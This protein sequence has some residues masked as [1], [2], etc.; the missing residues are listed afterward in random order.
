[1]V[2][3]PVTLKA[4]LNTVVVMFDEDIVFEVAGGNDSKLLLRARYIC[5][6]PAQRI[7]VLGDLWI[8]A[9]LVGLIGELVSKL[10]TGRVHVR[11]PLTK[12]LDSIFVLVIGFSDHLTFELL[13]IEL[14][15]HEGTSDHNIRNWLERHIK[16]LLSHKAKQFHLV[17]S[18]SGPFG[19]STSGL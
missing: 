4:K 15:N 7:L 13:L 5:L 19:R 17:D 16:T 12:C 10:P 18:V 8:A 3:F 9:E 6:D 2:E 14:V 1:M 11:N